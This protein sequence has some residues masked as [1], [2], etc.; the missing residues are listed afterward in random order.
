MFV[1]GYSGRIPGCS[2]VAEFWEHVCQGTNFS[3]SHLDVKEN[4]IKSEPTAT[5]L[6]QSLPQDS[7][8]LTLL[9]VVYEAI[10]DASYCLA[11]LAGSNT[12]VFVALSGESSSSDSISSAE[13][14]ATI[15]ELRG[16]TVELQGGSLVALDLASRAIRSGALSRAMVVEGGGWAQGTGALFFDWL[17]G[18]FFNAMYYCP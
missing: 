12:G 17:L 16:P 11:D 2:S 9:Q 1:T 4:N 6:G 15:F 7:P 13:Q 5:F 18:V 14:I 3:S 10:S 8:S